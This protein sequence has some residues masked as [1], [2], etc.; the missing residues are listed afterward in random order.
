VQGRVRSW[1]ALEEPGQPPLLI[2]NIRD[3]RFCGN[4]GRWVEAAGA[5][6]SPASLSFCLERAKPPPGSVGLPLGPPLGPQTWPPFIFSRARFSARLF[7]SAGTV[8]A[9]KSNGIFLVVD[10]R[11]GSWYKKCYDPGKSPPPVSLLHAVGAL[12]ASDVTAVHREAKQQPSGGSEALMQST[13]VWPGIP[14]VQSVGTTA[15]P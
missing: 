4:V 7:G 10:L 14:P 5:A 15:R 11:G 8:R 3:N 6:C 1:V 12:H 2:L 13:R 9:H